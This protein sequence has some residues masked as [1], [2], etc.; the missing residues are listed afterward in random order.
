MPY[1]LYVR[2]LCGLDD[3]GD[4]DGHNDN[5]DDNNDDGDDDDGHDGKD[6]GHDPARATDPAHGVVRVPTTT[7][8]TSL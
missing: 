8:T 1:S 2:T 4:D 3:D 7:T 5:E 6:D